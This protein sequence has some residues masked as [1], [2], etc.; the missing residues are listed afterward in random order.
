M[1]VHHRPANFTVGSPFAVSLSSAS[2]PR[3]RVACRLCA[4]LPN[5]LRDRVAKPDGYPTLRIIAPQCRS[6]EIILVENSLVQV[7]DV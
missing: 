7:L 2:E 1:G 4:K 5:L 6:R 3:L